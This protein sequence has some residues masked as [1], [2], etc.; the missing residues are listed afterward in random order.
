MK[1]FN[2]DGNL[3]PTESRKFSCGMTKIKGEIGTS[4]DD[5]FYMR[6]SDAYLSNLEIF[7]SSDRST[8]EDY[9]VMKGKGKELK[10]N[11][12]QCFRWFADELE[13]EK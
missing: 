9:V 11:M 7:A 8:G 13:K 1:R 5:N 3:R 10:E 4:E 12:I 2:F 6:V